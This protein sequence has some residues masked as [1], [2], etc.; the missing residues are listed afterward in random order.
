MKRYLQIVVICLI[1][2]VSASASEDAVV[3]R[4]AVV[5]SK[6]SSASERIA[7]IAAGTRVNV[8]SRK[9]GW[10]EIFSEEQAI[11][12]WV[13]GY[14]VREGN[15]GVETSSHSKSDSRGFLAG[16]ASLSRRASGFFKSNSNSTSSGTATIG[17]RGLSEEEIRSA[18]ADFVELE[19][20]KGFASN[21]SRASAFANKGKLKAKK[22]A[23]IHGPKKK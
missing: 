16:L 2:T 20:M 19:K 11:I 22:V 8:F 4:E 10:K 9:G 14:Q 3:V 15:Y 7:E 1:A 17:V 13:R 5:F 21:G 12:G 18:Q 23:Y 6:A